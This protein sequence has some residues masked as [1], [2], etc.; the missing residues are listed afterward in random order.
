MFDDLKKM[1]TSVLP[2]VLDLTDLDD[3]AI[4]MLEEKFGKENVDEIIA[5]IKDG[6]VEMTE[7]Q[8]MASRFGIPEQATQLLV[9]FYQK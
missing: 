9:K 5:V 3:K 7:I 6:K 1:A 2:N 4:A 8:A